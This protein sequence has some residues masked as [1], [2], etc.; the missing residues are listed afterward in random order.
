M[1][2]LF[3][4]FFLIFSAALPGRTTFILILLGSSTKHRT[5]LLG[6]LPAFFLQCI[7][8]VVAGQA[9]KMLP[10]NWVQIGAGILFL[11]FAFKFW[12]ES[13]STESAT[14]KRL[15]RSIGSIFLLIFMAELGDVSQL[16]IA[17]CAARSPSPWGILCIS[18]LA[19]SLIAVIAVYAGRLLTN[20]IGAATLQKAA[21]I[22]FFAFGSF[23]LI[24]NAMAFIR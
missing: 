6:S 19:M 14:S 16:A 9:L 20:V 18:I 7:I 5:V 13:R 23:L 17:S 1:R 12:S 24:S 21:A 4:T 10:Q 15:E 11:Y 8:A 2:D 3:L 22:I